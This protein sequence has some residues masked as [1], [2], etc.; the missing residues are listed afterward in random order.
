MLSSGRRPRPAI[1]AAGFIADSPPRRF[2]PR[3]GHGIR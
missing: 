2:E 3:A 1:V